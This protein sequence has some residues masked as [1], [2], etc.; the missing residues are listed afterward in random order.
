MDSGRPKT[1]DLDPEQYTG[2]A[3][4]GGMTALLAKCKVTGSLSS[5]YGLI[6]LPFT[7]LLPP[8]PFLSV[9]IAKSIH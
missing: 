9:L 2:T 3:L 8:L 4:T 7:S 5:K 1:Y 6:Y